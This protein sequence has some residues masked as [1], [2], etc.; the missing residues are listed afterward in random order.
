M[1]LGIILLPLYA[2]FSLIYRMWAFPIIHVIGLRG[3]QIRLSFWA[4]ARGF[5]VSLGLPLIWAWQVGLKAHFQTLSV[6]PQPLCTVCL[7][8]GCNVFHLGCDFHLSA[9]GWIC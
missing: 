1:L 4:D 7:G 2:R 5:G 8:K 3:E 9:R 6:A